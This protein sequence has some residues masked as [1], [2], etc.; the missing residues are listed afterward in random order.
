MPPPPFRPVIL[1][2]AD[3]VGRLLRARREELGLR[4]E[5]VAG[6]IEVTAKALGNAEA[7]AG[8]MPGGRKWLA[9]TFFWWAQA[10]GLRAVMMDEAS[11]EAAM[12][13]SDAPAMTLAAPAASPG[14]DGRKPVGRTVLRMRMTFTT[15]L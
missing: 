4:I 5:D 13:A 7:A 2:S 12:E 11:A 14:R 9:E 10:L 15:P 1:R 8:A 3:Q 6:D